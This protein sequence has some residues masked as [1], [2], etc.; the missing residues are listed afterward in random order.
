[1]IRYRGTFAIFFQPLDGPVA[2]GIQHDPAFSIQ[3]QSIRPVEVRSAGIHT[4]NARWVR[5]AGVV[6][7]NG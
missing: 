7:K 4:A 1:M 6:N 3:R 2:V 5:I